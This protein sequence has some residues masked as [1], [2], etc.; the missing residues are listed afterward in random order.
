MNPTLSSRTVR[1]PRRLVAAAVPLALAMA[2]LAAPTTATAQPAPAAGSTARSSRPTVTASGLPGTPMTVTLVTGDKITLTPAAN[3]GPGRYVVRARTAPRADGAAP[4]IAVTDNHPAGGTDEVAALPEDAQ[5]Y[6]VSGS[7]DQGLFDVDYLARHETDGQLPVVIK[8]TTPMTDAALTSRASSLPAST[9]LQIIN[10]QNAAEVSVELKR[11][12]AFWDAITGA[13]DPTVQ[14]SAATATLADGIDAVWLAGHRTGD[15]T[16]ATPTTE[17]LYTVTATIDYSSLHTSQLATLGGSIL[18]GLSGAGTGYRYRGQV[19]DDSDKGIYLATFQVPAGMYSEDQLIT[20]NVG[21]EQRSIYF[22]NPEFRVTNDTQIAFNATGA[23]KFSITT[24]QPTEA[25]DTAPQTTRSL[26]DGSYTS[27]L[28]FGTYGTA[29]SDFWMTPTAPVT[30]GWYHVKT[31]WLLG[32]PLISAAVTV[33]HQVR[34]HPVYPDYSPIA[35]PRVVPF[36]GSKSYTLIDAG[37]GS[38]D[39]F[40]K[41]DARGKLALIRPNLNRCNITNDQLQEVLKAGAAGLLIDPTNPNAVNG[42]CTIPISQQYF[43]AVPVAM[44]FA[45]IS[46]TEAKTLHGLLNQGPVTVAVADYGDTPYVYNL[47]FAQEGKIPASLQY[48]I[49]PKQLAH[50]DTSY[51][52]SQLEVVRQTDGEWLPDDPPTTT[53]TIYDFT[54]PATRQ[55]YYGP[56]RP[57]AVRS[58]SVEGLLSGW[59]RPRRVQPARNGN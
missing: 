11:A 20:V 15:G 40:A 49:T 59:R 29:I 30:T 32:H 31:D 37:M 26:P 4:M 13:A 58:Y 18:Y 53:G 23:S 44:P 57:D 21:S 16:H 54:A 6:I 39:D 34:L 48:Q 33:P 42:T 55:M 46:N 7:L 2:G 5:P 10:S 9:I 38:S 25:Y 8:Y 56:V 47:T 51:H 50:R 52:A 22:A 41:L 43:G 14:S 28:Y 45:S 17:P 19:V 24:P 27:T 35:K 36:T 12:S 1:R 3:V